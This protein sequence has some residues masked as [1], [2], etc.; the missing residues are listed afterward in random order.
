MR[1]VKLSRLTA[2]CLAAVCVFAVAGCGRRGGA[3]S[4]DDPPPAP[5]AVSTTTQQGKPAAEEPA[6]AAQEATT[7]LDSVDEML[8]DV[9]GDL[10]SAEATPPD[11]D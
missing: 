5:P 4:R 1:R 8:D 6:K 10:S 2:L 3:P 11:A 7:D 9:Q